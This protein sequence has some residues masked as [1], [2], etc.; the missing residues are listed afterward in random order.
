ML[1]KVSEAL[2]FTAMDSGVHIT[3]STCNASQLRGSKD[4]TAEALL[5]DHV[6]QRSTEVGWSSH[7]IGALR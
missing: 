7:R 6:H 2:T 1:N 4:I 3:V 5:P